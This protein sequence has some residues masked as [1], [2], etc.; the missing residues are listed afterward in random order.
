MRN[1]LLVHHCISEIWALL[2]VAGVVN[3][4]RS[5]RSSHEPLLCS[6]VSKRGETEEDWRPETI[7]LS[8][9]ILQSNDLEPLV[10]TAVLTRQIER[11]WLR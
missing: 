9:G 11:P 8:L 1:L 7:R 6:T 3:C 10:R 4:D 2:S 5:K